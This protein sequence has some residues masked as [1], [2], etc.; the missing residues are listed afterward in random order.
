MSVAFQG[1]EINKN[2]IESELDRSN[3]NNL[4]GAPA[5]D[6]IGLFVNNNRNTSVLT[7]TSDN[8]IDTTGDN[9]KDTVYIDG[10][11]AVFTDKT[12]LFINGVA[13][14]VKNSNNVDSFQLS[15][16]R[17]L[18]DTVVPITGDYIRYDAVSLQNLSNISRFRRLSEL[19][20]TDSDR[21]LG[22]LSYAESVFLGNSTPKQLLE[23]IEADLDFYK[24]KSLKSVSKLSNFSGSKLMNAYGYVLIEDPDN[25]NDSGFTNSTPGLF[26][27][28]AAT[29]SGI[30]AFSS[31][32]NPW[33]DVTLPISLTNITGGSGYTNGTYTSVPLTPVTGVVTENPVATITV[34]GGAVTAVSI[35]NYGSGFTA[36]TSFTA[37]AASIGGTGSGF[38]VPVGTYLQTTSTKVTIGSMN[39]TNGSNGIV[40]TEKNAVVKSSVTLQDITTTVFT[41]KTPI[42]I[43]GQTYYLCLKKES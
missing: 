2:L 36:F 20:R 23:A 7:I 8:L 3:L 13:Y 11:R 33:L 15:S 10:G 26:I 14:Y 38:S 34:S 42:T 16:M 39:I 4:A 30:R 40:I 22:F 41:H 32:E 24:F 12:E 43:N 29:K 6:D 27:Y 19:N 25:L 5:A 35:T 17:D 18:S 21:K 28:N 37:A 1:F 9:I 31:N